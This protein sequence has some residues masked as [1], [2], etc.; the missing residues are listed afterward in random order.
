[1]VPSR[2]ESQVRLPLKGSR[3]LEE[4]DGTWSALSKSWGG[5]DAGRCDQ[6]RAVVP[7]MSRVLRRGL[8]AR[9]AAVS[10]PPSRL[11]SCWVAVPWMHR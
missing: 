8:L 11:P 2:V 10:P 7:A 6:K 1:M 5:H 9:P 4:R 3:I